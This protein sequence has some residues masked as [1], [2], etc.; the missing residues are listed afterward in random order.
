MGLSEHDRGNISSL[1]GGET[2]S[3]GMEA[4][5]ILFFLN[6]N[7]KISDFTNQIFVTSSL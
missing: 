4:F 1:I 5:F 7:Y 6:I 3:F 2:L